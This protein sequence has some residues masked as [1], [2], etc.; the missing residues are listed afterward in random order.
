MIPRGELDIS[1]TD[2]LAGAGYCLWG[3]SA[4]QESKEFLACLS[5]RS[6][7]DLLLEA[8]KLPEGSEILI[9]DINIPGMFQIL[10][11]H[12]LVAIPLPVNDQTLSVSEQAFEEALSPKTKAV[13]FTHLFGSILD[14][15]HL[16]KIAKQH[17]LLVIE[18]CAQ[19]FNGVYLGHFESDVAMF[20]FGMIKTN[21]ALGGA[22]IYLKDL[23]LR[24]RMHDLQERLPLQQKRKFFKKL[25][26]AFGIKLLCSKPIYSLFYSILGF[27]GKDPDQILAGMVRGFSGGAIL[28]KIRFRPCHALRLLMERKIRSFGQQ[29]IGSRTAYGA[30]ILSKI[31]RSMKIGTQ[32]K[33]SFWVLPVK[34]DHPLA[35]IGKLRDEGFDATSKASSMV[36][37]STSRSSKCNLDLSNILYLPMWPKMRNEQKS[38]L[39]KVLHDFETNKTI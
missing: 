36:K 34:T 30:D 38:K 23:I 29:S 12:H 14:L 28:V 3:R 7:F 19:A 25:V 4:E 31:P 8:L 9:T 20:S 15:H 2:I 13:V 39:L 27:W 32:A 37:L 16:I 22:R 17:H 21:T 10:T 35:L 33:H 11:A 18:D 1:Y 5:V 26:V 6:G 24:E